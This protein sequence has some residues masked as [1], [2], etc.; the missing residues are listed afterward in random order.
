M[1]QTDSGKALCDE[2]L[3]DAQK[4]ADRILKKADSRCAIILKQADAKADTVETDVLNDARTE[5]KRQAVKIMAALPIEQA[6]IEL[7]T[8]EQVILSILDEARLQIENSGDDPRDQLIGRLAIEATSAIVA[9]NIVFSAGDADWDRLGDGV[10]ERIR[11]AVQEATGRSVTLD[12]KHDSDIKGGGLVA[13]S[14][15]GHQRYDNTFGTRFLRRSPEVRETVFDRLYSN[16]NNP[17][18]DGND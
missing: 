14:G 5:A 1:E 13:T 4:K 7:D 16:S 18:Q 3:K 15:D 12:V 10:L 6:R 2:I 8:C 17:N 9:E 11:S